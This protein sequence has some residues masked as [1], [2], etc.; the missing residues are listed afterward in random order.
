MGFSLSPAVNV[1]EYDLTTT[2]PAVATS[3]VGYAGKFRWG[4]CF[5]RNQRQPNA[6]GKYFGHQP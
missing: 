6:S 4:D 5:K 1:T 2:I 3:I